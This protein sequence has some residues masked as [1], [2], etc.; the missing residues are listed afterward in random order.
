MVLTVEPGI[1]I[2]KDY[3][4]V[5]AEWRGIGVRIE[6][7]ILVTESGHENLTAAIPKTV[8]E[9]ERACAR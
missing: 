9:V 1:Y 3:D 7:D 6:D 5:P 8:A 4:K 2:G